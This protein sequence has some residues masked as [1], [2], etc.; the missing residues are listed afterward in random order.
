MSSPAPGL[1]G[2][3]E[4]P[5]ALP[6]VAVPGASGA[7]DIALVDGR[8][9]TVEPASGPPSGLLALPGFADLHVHADR[10]FVRGPR[11]PRSFDEARA[12]AEA[13]RD[14]STA[15][16]VRDRARRLFDR[17]R[18]HGSLRVRSHVD[19]PDLENVRPREGVLAAREE[20]AGALDVEIV[21]FSNYGLDPAEPAARAHLGAALEA[22]ADLLGAWAAANPNP[23]ASLDGLLDLARETGAPVDVHLDEHLDPGA[24]LLEHLADA[25]LARGLEGRVTAG[26]CCALSTLD[27]A[28]AGRIVAKV[29][30]AGIT[31]I[32][33][34]ALN[35]Y[36]QDRGPVTPRR[37]GVTLVHE[38]LA[39]DVPVRFASDNVADVFFPWG[40]ADPLEAAFV[41]GIGAHVDDED[42]LLAGICDGR[43]RIEP[44]DPADLVLI[45]ADSVRDAIARRPRG[46]V[47]LR[48]GTVGGSDGTS[49][50]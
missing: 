1:P 25:T 38:L 30:A 12:F 27:E 24:V 3:G 7:V 8:V 4:T 22:G 5:A 26:H 44:G 18:T 14:R 46:R 23:R 45:A 20:V 13:V 49:P 48:A 9:A 35:L 42:A 11:P 32:A 10:A 29:A 6:G 36:L 31:V 41:A 28:A 33:L 17:A 40:D 15:H 2:L 19:H 37:R 47:V 39:A 16:E 34:T 43:C 21:A 50:G